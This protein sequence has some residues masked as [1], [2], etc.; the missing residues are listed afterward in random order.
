VTEHDDQ[1]DPEQD[2]RQDEVRRLLGELPD[3]GPLPADVA[4]RLDDRLAALVA[5]RA[6]GSEHAEVTDLA[7]ARARRRRRRTALV[8]AASVAVLGIGIGT[9]ADDLLPGGG[10][11]ESATTADA[12]GD[13]MMREAAPDAPTDQGGA[14]TYSQDSDGAPGTESGGAAA[15]AR[16][17]LVRS[18]TLDEDLARI[19]ARADQQRA[20]TADTPGTAS[21]LAPCAVP[22]LADGDQAVPVRFD[23]DPATLVLR[24]PSG[25][26]RE[27]Q[28][29][30]CDTG[31]AL[32]AQ[33]SVPAR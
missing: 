14:K 25:G 23:G 19:A 22:T 11:S 32:L 20:L 18:A 29:Y 17:A 8:A 16:R 31:D 3:P 9:V 30:A 4:A 6:G 24:G 7:A 12:G 2:P 15:G 1:H 27:A 21:A 10:S 26:T 33:G 28:V 13:S 5:E